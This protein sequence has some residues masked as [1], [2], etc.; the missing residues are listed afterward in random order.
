[1]TWVAGFL[2]CLATPAPF[3]APLPLQEPIAFMHVTVI[4][5]SG[6]GPRCDQTVLITG[7][8]I[9]A[10]GK[11]GT[12]KLPAGARIVDATGRFLIPGL[13]DMHV[14]LGSKS[15]LPLFIANGVTGVRTMDGDPEYQ[16]WRREVKAGAVVGPRMVIASSVF[17]GPQSYFGDHLKVG[18]ADE[19][20]EAVRKARRDGAE[21]I[22]VHDLIPRE[23]YFAIVDEA[24]KQGLPVAGHVPAA[25]TPEEVSD[26]GQASIE[27]LTRMDDLSLDGQDRGRAVALFDR[28][29]KNHT[30]QCPTLVMTRNYT[31]LA[32]PSLAADPRLRYVAPRR[33]ES[34]RRMNDGSL[35]VRG[36]MARKQLYRK[37]QAMVGAMQRA[38]VGILAGTD[39][40]NSYLIPGFSLHDELAILVECGLT[41]MQALQ[42]ATRNPAR[43]LGREQEPGTLQ[44]GSLADLV[45]L[46]AD[47]LADI[48][49]VTQVR[50]VVADGRFYDRTALD[51]LLTEAEA[52][53]NRE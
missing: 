21:F 13:W 32:N 17:D 12:L 7:D 1:M 25:M 38:G 34:W 2:L 36:W 26:A 8:R 10:L 19:A 49:N 30:W 18:T 20:R 39:L 33:R 46:D 31:L 48:R 37:R 22:K 50:A 44:K 27:H 45:L 6:A 16:A 11:T 5:G 28:F 43:F 53:A 15:A 24:R 4:D 40:A 52:A 51:R 42:A 3:P 9:T 35:S 41:P 14:H 47:P 23:A 29:R